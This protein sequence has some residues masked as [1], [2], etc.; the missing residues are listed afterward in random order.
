MA[1]NNVR[2]FVLLYKTLKEILDPKSKQTSNYY[3]HLHLQERMQVTEKKSS[4][5]KLLIG[6]YTI[7]V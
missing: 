7:Y 2:L 6:T 4:R 3:D 5:L 1:L